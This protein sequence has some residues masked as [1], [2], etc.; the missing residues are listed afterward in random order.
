MFKMSC[1]DDIV[2]F[3]WDFISLEL[4]FLKTLAAVQQWSSSDLSFYRSLYSHSFIRLLRLINGPIVQ[5]SSV[6]VSPFQ[7]RVRSFRVLLVSLSK[8]WDEIKA[9]FLEAESPPTSH[10]GIDDDVRTLI[11]EIEVLIPLFSFMSI[12]SIF[13]TSCVVNTF[14]ARSDPLSLASPFTFVDSL[15]LVIPTFHLF[16]HSYSL[17]WL[18]L[19]HCLCLTQCGLGLLGLQQSKG[20]KFFFY[21]KVFVLKEGLHFMCQW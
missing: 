10:L 17:S 18:C 16:I 1:C 13:V 8:P 19:R 4:R 9:L 15:S 6:Y 14:N 20:E 21:D 2:F 7:S 3:S 12:V 11:P 5:I